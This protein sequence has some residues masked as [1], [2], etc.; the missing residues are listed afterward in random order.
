[1]TENA[2][3]G[4]VIFATDHRRLADFYAAVTKLS[5]QLADDSVVVLRCDAY[6][7]VIH[8][9]AGEPAPGDPP[10]PRQDSYI[11][12]FFPVASLESARERAAALGG[13]LEPADKEWSA[14]GFRACEA[15]DPEGNVIQFREDGP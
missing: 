5:V 10:V 6:E 7:L 2:R 8:R 11:K 15:V 1:M 13:R 9:L 14:R 12:P 4:T 3:P